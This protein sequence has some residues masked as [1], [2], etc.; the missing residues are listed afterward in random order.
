MNMDNSKP[1]NTRPA[2]G[3]MN[4]YLYQID[5]ALYWL[6]LSSHD[7]VVSIETDD[8][9][10]TRL[11]NG[12]AI[13]SIYEQDKA[14]L[15]KKFPFSDTNI[16]L[17]KSI[18]NWLHFIKNNN[19]N[20]NNSRFILATNVPHKT[21]CIASSLNSATTKEDYETIYKN[22]LQITQSKANSKVLS[23]Y[24]SDFLK[25]S[26]IEILDLLKHIELFDDTYN[27]NRHIYKT[28]IVQSLFLDSPNVPINDFYS[29]IFGWIAAECIDLWKA[30]NNAVFKKKFLMQKRDFL[31]KDFERKPFIERAIEFLPVSISEKESAI[32]SMFVKQLNWIEVEEDEI[33]MAID[34]FYRAKKAKTSYAREGNIT[35]VHLKQYEADLMGHWDK[36]SKYQKRINKDY[37]EPD[38]GYHVYY[39]TIKYKGKLSGIEPSY[40]YLS[41]GT[42]H[43]LSNRLLIGW[44]P[45]WKTFSNKNRDEE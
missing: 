3:Q 1:I 16:N 32:S 10:V 42:Y 34:D 40:H 37:S 24:I 38:L 39:Q 5:R 44:H 26:K 36:E 22:L 4:G 43:D 9:I 20:L 6:C 33:M 19:I 8:D 12:D 15:K 23:P 31:V 13:E 41:N 29:I 25:F 45:N 27:E 35:N 17:W 28:E 30:G 2:S 7:A 14:S 11:K 18:I 21:K